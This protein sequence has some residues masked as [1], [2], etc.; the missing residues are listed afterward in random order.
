M[1]KGETAP[2]KPGD[3]HQQCYEA[4]LYYIEYRPRSEAEVRRHLIYK[5]RFTEESVSRAVARLRK[6]QLIDDRAFS[7]MWARERVSHRHKSSLMIK[8]ELMQKG[9]DGMIIE[10]VTGGIDDEAN[11]LR[12]GM[13]KARNLRGLEYQEFYK[14]LVAYLSRKGYS[15]EL[16]RGV[17]ARLWESRKDEKDG[18]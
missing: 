3:E 9:V 16:V 5:R 2:G 1:S 14:R 11:A 4:A 15:A 6:L 17:V 10:R 13:C 8:R 12:A 7:E 18:K